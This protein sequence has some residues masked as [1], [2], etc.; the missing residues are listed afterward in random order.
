MLRVDIIYTF[1]IRRVEKYIKYMY[2]I[3]NYIVV[4]GNIYCIRSNTDEF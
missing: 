3:G 1:I 4:R 2:I